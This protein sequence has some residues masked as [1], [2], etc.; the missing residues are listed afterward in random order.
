[1][2][3]LKAA[4]LL[5]CLYLLSCAV[6]ASPY[7]TDSSTFVPALTE[8]GLG[9]NIVKVTTLA[10]AGD[11]SL[12]DALQHKGPKII[13]FEVGGVIDLG[14]DS[15]VINSPYTTIAGQTAPS[16][17]ITL[18]RGGL[19]IHTHDVIVRHLRIRPGE[20]GQE[21]N[22]GWNSDALSTSRGAH[23][24]TID[25]C[26]LTWG[27]DENL[28]ASGPRFEGS[29]ALQWR[30]NT[31][32]D[33]LFSNNI[34]A[35]GL[36]NST[37]PKGEHSKG[38]LIHDNATGIFAT[39]NL[40]AHNMERNP[41]L[42]GGVHATLIN[43]FIYNPG[44]RAVH[45]NLLAREWEG[46]TFQ[47]GRLTAVGNV[48]RGGPSTRAGLPFLMIGGQGDLD[49]F[50]RDNL[51]VNWLG[52]PLPQTGRYTTSEA[53]IQVH[54]EPLDWPEGLTA[55]PASEVEAM[56]LRSAGA[57]PWDRDA[58]DR[59]VISDAAEGR[60]MIIDNEQEVGGYPEPAESRR[61]FE[62][63]QWNLSS[64]WIE[65]REPGIDSQSQKPTGSKS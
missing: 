32:H 53:K 40:F 34:I 23:R 41:L 38:L 44:S 55:L 19:S 39:G 18:I 57:R 42:K 37:H 63:G 46:Q 15:L 5:P 62:P 25:H 43:N 59:R 10:E 27:T 54:S 65:R 7:S 3:P 26:S 64:P 22:S 9:G 31:S 33:V 29:N 1:M 24:L 13:V 28:S 49:Y 45:Y 20:A 35:E 58:H 8:G 50:G 51:A 17:G 47:N 14:L 36:A 16:P 61:A 56:V 60:G 30:S 2:R 52:A 48:F 12:R 11:G 6:K 21:S 4:W